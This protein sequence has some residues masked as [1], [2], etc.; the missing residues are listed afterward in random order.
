VTVWLA[1]E[2]VDFNERIRLV[3]KGRTVFGD[4]PAPDAAVILEDARTRGDRQHP[5][6]ARIDVRR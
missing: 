1:P 3:V 4:Q 5:F 2:M 6:W